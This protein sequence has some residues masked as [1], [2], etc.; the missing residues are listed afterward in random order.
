[1]IP[2]PIP[3]TPRDGASGS[4]PP[5]PRS[6]PG[7]GPAADGLPRATLYIAALP[8]S[9]STMLANLLSTPPDR[10]ILVEPGLH[11]SPL[12]P[13]LPHQINRFL[14][15]SAGGGPAAPVAVET[16]RR[17][18]LKS[19]ADFLPTLSAWGL[20]EVGTEHRAVIA[21]T[22]PHKTIILV[23]DIRDA[24]LS[25]LEKHNQPGRY[26]EPEAQMTYLAECCTTLIGLARDRDPNTR[27]CRYEDLVSSPAERQA[28]AAWL[29]WPLDGDVTRNLDLYRRDYEVARHRGTISTGSVGRYDREPNDTRAA[30]AHRFGAMLDDFSRTFGY[31]AAV[32]GHE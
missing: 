24:L 10:W 11:S 1:M 30:V 4:Q 14:A 29:S 27:I 32:P 28:L 15:A 31:G 13:T 2:E 12:S 16:P 25:L 5:E 9:G 23:R 7:R 18:L 20:K 8:R 17:L 3:S 21:S 19:L 6:G 26:W 22:R